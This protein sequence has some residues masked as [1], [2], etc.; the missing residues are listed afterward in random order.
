MLARARDLYRTGGYGDP[1]DERAVRVLAE[2]LA[3]E[4]HVAQTGSLRQ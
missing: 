4:I 3:S 1:W 2:H